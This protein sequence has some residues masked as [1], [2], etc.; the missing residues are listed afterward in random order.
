M[1]GGPCRHMCVIP[2]APL[3]GTM[4]RHNALLAAALLATATHA[5]SIEL[6]AGM[7][8]PQIGNSF[9]YNTAAYVPPGPAGEALT[10]DFSGLTA[11]GTVTWN[12]FDPSE[13]SNAAAF[14]TATIAGSNGMDTMFYR[15]TASGF[16]RVGEWQNWLGVYNVEVPLTDGPLTLELPLTH[17]GDWSDAISAQF[18]IDGGGTTVRTGT[19]TGVADAYGWLQLPTGDPVPVLRVYT[20]LNETNTINSFIPITV[21]HK[22]HEYA[23]YAMWLGTPVLRTISDSLTSSLNVN[24]YSSSTEWLGEAALSVAAAQGDAFHLQLFPNPANDRVELVHTDAHAATRLQLFDATGKVVLSRE[25]G[26][27]AGQ[28]RTIDVQGLA[29]GLYTVQLTDAKGARSVKRLVIDR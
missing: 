19:I 7:N 6:N 3:I 9:T 13:Y 28:R 16:E 22:R 17:E 21:T 27:T 29:P 23:Y 12:W 20:R 1:A 24:Q 18:E 4:Q 8:V 2:C 5:Q 25:L 14:P 11:T 10:F 15:T 26:T